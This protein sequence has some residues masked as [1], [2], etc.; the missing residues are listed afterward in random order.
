MTIDVPGIRDRV[1]HGVSG[2]WV[3]TLE[4]MRGLDTVDLV[5]LLVS[6]FLILAAYEWHR[7]WI[8]RRG[9]R[10]ILKDRNDKKHELLLDILTDGIENAEADQKISRKEANDLY[11]ELQRK[12]GLHDLIP[13][14]RLAQL[15]KRSLKTDRILREKARREGKEKLVHI[16]GGPPTPITKAKDGVVVMVKTA[17]KFWPKP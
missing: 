7:S 14:K 1:F 17:K 4:V 2:A 16:P 5:T 10:M 3:S 15:V 11:M 12:L 13:K 8:K 6:L 9:F